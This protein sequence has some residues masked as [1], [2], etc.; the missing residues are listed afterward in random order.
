MTMAWVETE[1]C[2]PV[3]PAGV[4]RMEFVSEVDGLQDWAM[5]WPG[6]RTADW[7]VHLHGHGSTGDQ[8]FT[9]PDIAEH[10][11]GAY[12]QLG[13]GVLSANTRGNSWMSAP[14]A[15][16]LSA[17]L[18][19]VRERLGARRFYFL[20]GSMGGTANL[21]YAATHPQDVTAAAA[22]CPATDLASYHAWLLGHPTGVW[23]EIRRAIEL[24]YGGTPA[25]RPEAYAAHSALAH[26][27]RLTMPLWLAHGDADGLIPV[28]QSRRLAQELA[29]RPGFGYLEIPSGDHDAPLLRGGMIEWL[30]GII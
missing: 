5:A 9:R 13:L 29:G 3:A 10:W 20:S 4:R 22:L 17:L 6:L 19:E 23:D 21:I 16:D 1:C 14:A 27:D 2:F 30:R 8:I 15:V 7:V 24:A 11:L 28:E 12:R 25:Q 18:Q 26:A